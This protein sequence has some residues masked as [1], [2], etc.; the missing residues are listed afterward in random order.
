M[1]RKTDVIKEIFVYLDIDEEWRTSNIAVTYTK[2]LKGKLKSKLIESDCE[3]VMDL[4]ISGKDTSSV[5]PNE[6]IAFEII[7]DKIKVK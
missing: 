7:K 2:F 5:H 4:I 1:S 6:I 3:L